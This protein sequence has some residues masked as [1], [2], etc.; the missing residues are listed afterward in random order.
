MTLPTLAFLYLF[1]GSARAA[2][3]A[4]PPTGMFNDYIMADIVFVAIINTLFWPWLTLVDIFWRLS[5]MSD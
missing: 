1:I 3:V 5:E 2:A 4:V